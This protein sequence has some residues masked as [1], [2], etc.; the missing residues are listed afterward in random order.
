[1]K[2]LKINDEVV[3]LTGRKSEKGRTGKLKN[4][5]YKKGLVLV[6]GINIRKKAVRRSEQNPDGGYIEIERPLHI[7]NVAYVSKK[8]GKPTRIRIE[9]QDGKN[10]RIAVRDGSVLP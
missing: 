4:V 6:E 5:D 1:M 2:K 9:Q 7:S 8:D 10:V 3:V